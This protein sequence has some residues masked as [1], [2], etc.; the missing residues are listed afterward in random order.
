MKTGKT[1]PILCGTD[2][3]G[4]AGQAANVAAA[5]AVRLNAPLLLVHAKEMLIN[6]LTPDVN[7]TLVTSLRESLREEAGRLRGLGATVEEMLL[8]GEPDAALVQL[9]QEQE[10]RLLVVSSLGR[11]KPSRWF[12]GSVAERTAESSG[13]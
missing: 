13:L 6:A 4:N 7:T 2:F 8:A 9:A 5:L 12:I 3:S 11:R 10:A 1:F